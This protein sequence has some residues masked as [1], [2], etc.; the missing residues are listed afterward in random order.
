MARV[1]YSMLKDYKTDEDES[2]PEERKGILDGMNVNKDYRRTHSLDNF[3]SRQ[4]WYQNDQ[5]KFI[6]TSILIVLL[7][8]ILFFTMFY[9]NPQM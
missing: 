4:N 7:I 3:N 6:S 9:F 1:S 8:F 2:V 5:C